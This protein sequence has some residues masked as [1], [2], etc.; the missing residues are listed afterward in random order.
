MFII[1]EATGKAHVK[2]HHAVSH[3]PFA[4]W[5][6][7]RFVSPAPILPAPSIADAYPP[8]SHHTPLQ[9]AF[10]APHK[11]CLY[12]ARPHWLATSTIHCLSFNHSTIIQLLDISFLIISANSSALISGI[13][14]CI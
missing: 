8:M 14:S 9:N 13:F 5:D 4:T 10:T 3:A 11:A 7:P 6:T 1:V 2:T 12:G